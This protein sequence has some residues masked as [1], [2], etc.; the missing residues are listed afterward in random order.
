MSHEVLSRQATR[1]ASPEE[2]AQI[3]QFLPAIVLAYFASQNR[4]LLAA[5]CLI[6][7]VVEMYRRGMQLDSLQFALSMATLQSGSTLLSEQELDILTAR[8][9]IV[10]LTLHE[11]GC[12]VY[13]KAHGASGTVQNQQQEESL[14]EQS[15]RLT[16]GLGRFVKQIVDMYKSGFDSKRMLLQ[17]SLAGSQGG[18]SGNQGGESPFVITMQQNTRL[19]VLTLEMIQHSCIPITSPFQST[20]PHENYSSSD[21][22]GS[23]QDPDTHPSTSLPSA[24]SSSPLH[25][26]PTAGAGRSQGSKPFE[27]EL[28]SLGSNASSPMTSNKRAKLEQVDQGEEVDDS[29]DQPGLS[30]SKEDVRRAFREE[31]D[32]ARQLTDASAP[33]ERAEPVNPGT[34]TPKSAEPLQNPGRIHSEPDQILSPTGYI[35]GFLPSSSR[36]PAETPASS[37]SASALQA[38]TQL[39]PV[40]DSGGEHRLMPPDSPESSSDSTRRPEKEEEGG[41][42]AQQLFDQLIQDEFAQTGGLLPLNHRIRGGRATPP[43]LT[44]E[45]FARWLS[46]SYMTLAVMGVPHPHASQQLGWAWVTLPLP[47]DPSSLLSPSQNSLQAH[48]LAEIVGNKLRLEEEEDY[49]RQGQQLEEEV[50]ESAKAM[51]DISAFQLMTQADGHQAQEQYVVLEDPALQHTSTGYNVVVQQLELVSL[52]RAAVMQNQKVS[53]DV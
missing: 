23:N 1:S 35:L 10:M 6:E 34:F 22:D 26:P 49:R 39:S 32:E 44:A 36:D 46:T 21:S 17:Q 53:T 20:S 52:T 9:G 40:A 47:A 50:S 25:R 2:D 30:S 41:W 42:T 11:V 7:T 5:D 12:A 43:H 3:D 19:V 48:R 31:E 51:R 4:S 45:L 24:A 33:P 15:K 28:N 37:S 38:Q 27:Q 16:R 8:C 14:N 29:Q 18:E 13:P